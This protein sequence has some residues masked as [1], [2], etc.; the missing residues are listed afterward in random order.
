[1][2]KS[3]TLALECQEVDLI[4]YILMDWVFYCMKDWKI[5]LSTEVNKMVSNG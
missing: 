5:S 1:M 4:K 2:R 3:G